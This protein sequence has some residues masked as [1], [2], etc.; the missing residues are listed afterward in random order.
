MTRV[1]CLCLGLFWALSAVAL[2]ADDPD[3]H[4]WG[5]GLQ[6]NTPLWGGLSVKYMG[7]GK[8]HIQAVEHYKQNG[9]GVQSLMFGL[10]TPIIVVEHPGMDILIAPAVGFRREERGWES[11]VLDD[12]RINPG[13]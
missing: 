9:G 12:G 1:L 8:V 6:G 10:Q 7:L 3:A 13:G 4:T 5:V 2:A 11:T